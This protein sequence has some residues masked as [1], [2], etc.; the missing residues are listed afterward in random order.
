MPAV[1]GECIIHAMHEGSNP[2]YSVI[3]P[4]L[5]EERWL[6]QCIDGLRRQAI[7]PELVEWIFVDNGSTDRSAAIV[8]AESRA[9]LFR[10]EVKD[11]YLARNT[12]IGEAR[13]RHLVFLDADCIAHPDWLTAIDRRI[14]GSDVAIVNGFVGYPRPMSLPLQLMEEY[15]D[16]QLR[17]LSEEG[18]RSCLLGHA[19]NMAVRADVFDAVGLFKPMP[20][21]GDVEIIHR[22][23]ARCPSAEVAYVPEAKVVHAEVAT[24]RDYLRKMHECGKHLQTLHQLNV[25]QPLDLSA[26]RRVIRQC[27]DRHRYGVWRML[28]LRV[29]IAVA[30]MACGLGASSRGREDAARS[31]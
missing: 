28:A 21:V 3:V 25:L 19:G 26:R 2:R 16:A 13:G 7:D 11:P 5:N 8:Q 31:G 4:F 9:R 27:G 1:G 30:W 24:F 20:V 12:G 6:P 23:L 17:Y 29:T 14:K 10:Q 18:P 15:E 22:Y